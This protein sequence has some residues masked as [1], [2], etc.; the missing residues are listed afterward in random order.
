MHHFMKRLAVNALLGGVIALT[1]LLPGFFFNQFGDTPILWFK[2]KYFYMFWGFGVA[3]CACPSFRLAVV[4]MSG[5]ALLELTQFGSLA[6]SHEYI[7]PFAIG[8]MLVEY[9]EVAETAAANSIHFL[10]VPAVVVVPYLLCL[11]I[12]RR[13][14]HLPVKNRWFVAAVIAFLL[15]PLLRIKTHTDREDVINFFPTAKNPTLINTLN[16]YSLY[17]G[18]ML[19]ERLLDREPVI[20]FPM[21]DVRETTTPK[22]PMTV[23]VVMGESLTPNHMSL[24][25]YSRKTTPFLDSLSSNQDFYFGKGYSAANATRSAL[26][27]FYTLQ[28]H[29]LDQNRLRK[30]DS[31]LFLLAK[32][33]GFTTYYLSAQNSNCLNGVSLGSID[34]MVTSDSRPEVFEND[35]DEGLLR[36]VREI[37][38]GGKRFIV[39]HQRNVHLPY[40][41]NTAHRPKFQHFNAQGKSYTEASINSYDNAVLYADYLYRELLSELD[42]NGDGPLFAFFTSDHGENLGENGHWGHDQLDLVSPLVPIMVYTT[43]GNHE[44]VQEIRKN[45]PATHYQLGKIVARVLGYDIRNPAEENGR[46]YVNGVASLG[47]SGFMQF[48]LDQHGN[49]QQLQVIHSAAQAIAKVNRQKGRES[50]QSMPR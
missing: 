49:P 23:V 30:Q 48:D 13:T 6:F 25:G 8:L 24:F 2:D 31:N 4:V 27:M 16:S 35:K 1:L 50:A 11:T 3:L 40:Q 20:D 38:A 34:V 5:L 32:R 9:L 41:E 37:P 15:F 26:P 12:L 46:V 19:P 43:G 42:E 36:L 28:Y 47:R 45:P 10:Y 39:V 44:F 17:F 7:T 29:P 22:S 33:H 14:W 21:Y 18:V